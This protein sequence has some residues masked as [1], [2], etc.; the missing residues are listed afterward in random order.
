LKRA[1]DGVLREIIHKLSNAQ[2][3]GSGH[4]PIH[5]HAVVMA[6]LV[7]DGAMVAIIMVA[8]RDETV[9]A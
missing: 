6:A 4:E 7:L 1:Y 8:F 2:I 9:E 5:H 3:Q